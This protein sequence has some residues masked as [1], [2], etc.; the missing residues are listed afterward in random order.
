MN[1]ASKAPRAGLGTRRRTDLSSQQM[2]W[3]PE[4]PPCFKRKGL[5]F[6]PQQMP[7]TQTQVGGLVGLVHHTTTTGVCV[8]KHI[9]YIYMT[10]AVIVLSYMWWL[11]GVVVV[12]LAQGLRSPSSSPTQAI[13]HLPPSGCVLALGLR[14]RVQAIPRHFPSSFPSASNQST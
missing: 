6:A 9:L 12:T 2:V 4:V 10:G 8:Y 1:H 13:F 3:A 5:E 7:G 14:S 11:C